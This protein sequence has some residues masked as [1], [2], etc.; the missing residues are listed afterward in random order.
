MQIIYI[1]TY[2]KNI[3]SIYPLYIHTHTCAYSDWI[4]TLQKKK[5]TQMNI[6]AYLK[7]Y[8]NIS[9]SSGFVGDTAEIFQS[10]YWMLNV[11]KIC[12]A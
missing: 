8:F 5:E 4:N 1:F 10:K 11:R 12:G 2:I 7:K 6:S 3:L 9:K